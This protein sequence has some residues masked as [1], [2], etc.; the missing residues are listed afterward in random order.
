MTAT[1]LI[2]IRK[3][4]SQDIIVPM[5]LIRPDYLDELLGGLMRRGENVLHVFLTV[6]EDI[7]RERIQRQTMSPDPTQ[8]ER[9][10]DWRLAQVDR[11]LAARDVMPDGTCFLDT[12]LETP[13][14][15]ADKVL[16]WL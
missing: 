8:N 15:L 11:C 1:A 2:E 7:L 14:L 10:R 4:Y 16:D 3:H 13:D 12:R 5:T 6:D 9:I